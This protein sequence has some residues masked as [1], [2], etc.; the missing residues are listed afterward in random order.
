MLEHAF[1]GFPMTNYLS[2]SPGSASLL[3]WAALVGM[4]LAGPAQ[5]QSATSQAD[6]SAPKTAG[7]EEIVITG[8][9]ASLEK[10]LE[11]K[12]ESAVVQDS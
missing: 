9:R 4:T 5:S 11:M 1:E 6:A 12:K 8:L 10:S 3:V 2:R 7:V